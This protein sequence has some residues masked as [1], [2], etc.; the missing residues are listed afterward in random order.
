MATLFGYA[1]ST[2]LDGLTRITDLSQIEEGESYYI[3]SDRVKFN[4]ESGGDGGTDGNSTFVK[5]MSNYQNGYSA[6]NWDSP[7]SNKYFVYYGDL[8]PDSQGFVWKAE[9]VGDKWAFLNMDL[10]KYLGNHN[11]GETDLRF[12]DTAIGYTLTKLPTH[13]G[14]YGF[15]FTNDSYLNDYPGNP[16]INVHQYPLRKSRGVLALADWSD[17]NA[18]DA[19]Q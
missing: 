3:V 5:A 14:S 15:S 10:N 8:N 1:Q 18:T 4:Y 19:D 9:K 17:A 6:T 16:Y 7:G 13:D 12:S 11:P 2:V